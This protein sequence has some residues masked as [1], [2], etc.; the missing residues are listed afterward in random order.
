MGFTLSVLY[1][2]TVHL[3]AA[4]VFGPL[5]P[6]H[7][8]AILAVLLFLVSVPK[9]G[10][11]LLLK[12]P[13]SLALIGLALS[14]S[15][16]ELFRSHWPTGAALAFLAFLPSIYAYFMVCLH[17]ESK[18]K[19][20]IL[21]L[22]LLFVCLFDICRGSI[23][24]LSIP[25]AGLPVRS[26]DLHPGVS[27][28]EAMST[29][30]MYAMKSDGGE[31]FYRLRG[32]GFLNDPNDFAQLNVCVIPLLF[33]FWR[34][35]RTLLNIVRVILPVAALL[36][37]LYLTHSRGSLLALMAMLFFAVRRRLGVI[38][39]VVGSGAILAVASVL[40]F[41]GGREISAQSGSDRTLLWGQGLQLLRNHKLFGV[42]LGQM[43]SYTNY[44]KTAHNSIVVCA[45][46]L[47]I[48]GLFCWSSFLY[49]T[50]RDALAIASP[51]KARE[52]NSEA[53]DE[54]PISHALTESE[55]ADREEI[56]RF[57]RSVLLSLTGFLV[58]GWFLSR[59]FVLTFFLLG[60][61]TEVVFEMAL[62]RGMI[63]PRQHFARVFAYSAGL[64]ILLLMVV[65]V[66][67]RFLNA[68]R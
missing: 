58:A 46:E 16:S 12:T 62:R 25:Q 59:A 47:G 24:L 42:G 64:S 3:G 48:A 54:E 61:I 23:D 15:F 60:G 2:V 11:S 34:P 33:I 57:G 40:Q 4:T 26:G 45:A 38:A 17:C 44:G 53:I 49:P 1:L 41:T 28:Q 50:L 63:R 32:Q 39:S 37:G 35:R 21:L 43:A 8:E 36:F 66:A 51:A 31:W 52:T 19:L 10:G 22:G 68:L 65:Y 18:L 29:P 55:T 27:E 67:L 56:N 20:Q 30:Y 7:I 14:V 6:F 5:A 13:Q 9:L